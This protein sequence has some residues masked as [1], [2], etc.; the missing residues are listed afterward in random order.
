MGMT[1]DGVKEAVEAFKKYNAVA[2]SNLEK[3]LIKSA[4][5]VEREA[6]GLF[7]GRD[8]ESVSGEP[9]RVDTGRLR[10]S[11]THRLEKDSDGPAAYVGTN[12][13]Y[14]EDVE[15]GTSKTWPHPFLKPA[16]DMNKQ[17]I[18]AAIAKAIQEAANA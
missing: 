11:I 9:P 15:H 7:K 2:G 10:A 16:L 3:V 12:V 4:I 18:Q 1:I 13:E 6:K 17:E 5:V 14:A 8:D